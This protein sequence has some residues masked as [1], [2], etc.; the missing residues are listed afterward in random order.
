MGAPTKTPRQTSAVS[1]G[2]GDGTGRKAGVWRCGAGVGGDVAKE[3][4]SGYGLGDKSN[5][6]RGTK[7][8]KRQKRKKRNMRI[9]EVGRMVCW[10][11]FRAGVEAKQGQTRGG[12]AYAGGLGKSW[13]K[14][15]GKSQETRSGAQVPRLGWLVKER[16]GEQPGVVQKKKSNQKELCGRVGRGTGG[17]GPGEHNRDGGVHKKR[18]GYLVLCEQRGEGLVTA[19]AVWGARKKKEARPRKGQERDNTPRERRKER[20]RLVGGKCRGDGV[21]KKSGGRGLRSPAFRGSSYICVKKGK[22]ERGK[23]E[24]RERKDGGQW[25][26]SVAE[27]KPGG[28]KEKK[29]KGLGGRKFCWLRA[30]PHSSTGRGRRGRD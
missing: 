22:P 15:R 12:A 3:A 5:K 7:T 20:A 13:G 11:G 6:R 27:E 17:R 29:Q 16:E 8:G 2:R 24:G 21:K 28:Q 25:Y 23:N 10:V 1:D 30:K 4:R 26:V 18:G 19:E 14:K 9:W